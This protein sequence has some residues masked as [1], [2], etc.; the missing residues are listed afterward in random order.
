MGMRARMPRARIPKT[1]RMVL[2]DSFMVNLFLCMQTDG[3]F[4]RFVPGT[5][6]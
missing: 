5:F 4:T 6:V 1:I 2:V 3:R